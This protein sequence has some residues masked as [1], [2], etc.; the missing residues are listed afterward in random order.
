MRRKKGE[1]P[2]DHEF[3][4]DWTEK[5]KKLGMD[6]VPTI[7]RHQYL[8]YKG[9]GNGQYFHRRERIKLLWPNYQFH[10]W[11]DRR[12]QGVSNYHWVCW[13]GPGAS[14]KTSDAAIFG[15]E[16]WTQ[17]PDRTAVI[18]CSTTVKMLR[19]RI[20]NQVTHWHQSL[21]KGVGH[22]GDL[23]DSV[24]RIRWK[25]GDDK[26]GIFGIAVE[27]GPIEEVVQ[28]LI[29]IHT[30]RVLLIL[31]EAQGIREAIMRATFNMAKNPRFDCWLLG[32]PDDMHNPLVKEAE[33]L[34][35]WDSVVR[36]ETP[37]WETRGG[38]VE[39][40][41]LAQFF[42]GRK[43]PADD[44]PEERKRLPWLIN[45]DWVK[46]HLKSVNG[47][48]NDPTYW[49]QA[50]G[51]PPPQGL[52]STLL[53]DAEIVTFKCRDKAVWT[54]GYTR[55]A[56]LDPAFNGGDKAILQFGKR[57]RSSGLGYD[58]STRTWST[59]AG[60]TAWLIEFEEWMQVPID[61]ES[62]VPIHYQIAAH[63]RVECE[64]RGIPPH[65]FACAAAGEGGGL[66]SIF[67]ATWGAINSIEEGGA[68]S[69]RIIPNQF[70]SDGSPKTAKECYDTRASELCLG[71]REFA[72]ANGIRG[73]S[74]EAVFQ[75]C[76][77]RTFY[78]NGKWAA[79]GKTTSKGRTDEK[80]RPVKGFKSRMGFSP[81]HLD[82]DQILVEH[83]KMQGA[84][85]HVATA[86]DS[87]PQENPYGAQPA[88]DEFASENYLKPFHY[89]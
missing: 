24:T 14:G 53:S 8:A 29:G 74:N 64:K 52:E 43:S 20:W 61:A 23:L 58:E 72:L 45:S 42:D 41:G 10:R 34:E 16:Y 80:G 40:N 70:N 36:G 18:C 13:L 4:V 71:L 83:C 57:G 26:N 6:F 67:Q 86:P 5:A 17:A 27:D 30:E 77:R 35:S 12:L 39:G 68:P 84:E 65:E 87:Q 44:S 48:L 1:R 2:P 50:I 69:E 33:P 22:V 54:E 47:N 7:Q 15:V 49:A 63:V 9:G 73:M 32:N 82:T 37:E 75:A 66:V 76:A 51:F 38:P 62:S 3:G 31:D 46:N 28:N 89:A 25:P 60:Q 79:E 55:C 88:V 56:A 78:R 11:A 59:T 85:P 19:M 21:P 81:D